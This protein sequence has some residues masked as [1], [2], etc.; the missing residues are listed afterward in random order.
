MLNQGVY[1]SIL[2]A[3]KGDSSGLTMEIIS[4]AAEMGDKLANT[5]I[6]NTANYIGRSVAIVVNVIGP[7]TV[8]LGGEMTRNSKYFLTLVERSIRA[9]VILGIEQNLEINVSSILS[10]NGALGA[11]VLILN[12][13][14]GYSQL[15]DSI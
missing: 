10:Y 13:F 9:N 8:I 7:Q 3:I 5:V 4:T 15:G 2:D 11:I 12:D 14:L 6:E 1:S